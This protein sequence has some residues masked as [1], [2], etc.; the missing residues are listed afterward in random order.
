MN[1]PDDLTIPQRGRE[2]REMLLRLPMNRQPIS[3]KAQA[4]MKVV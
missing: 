2:D 3:R 1:S 4:A